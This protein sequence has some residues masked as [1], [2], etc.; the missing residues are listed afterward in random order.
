MG[1]TEDQWN[2]AANFIDS[3]ASTVT[4][5]VSQ[6]RNGGSQDAMAAMPDSTSGAGVDTAPGMMD[7]TVFGIPTP[8]ALAGAALVAYILLRK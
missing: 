8:I 7:G 3:M 4:S 2:E 5:S 6:L 1:W